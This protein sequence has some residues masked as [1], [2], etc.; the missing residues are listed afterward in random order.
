MKRL[1]GVLMI[2]AVSMSLYSCGVVEGKGEAEKIAESMFQDRINNGW[3][4]SDQYYS[5]LFWEK[6]DTARWSN[7]QNLVTKAHGELQSFSLNTWHIKSGVST[8]QLSGTLVTLLYENTYEQGHVS[9]TLLL[10]K[11]LADTKYS[12]IGHNLNSKRIQE[13]V[14]KG[15]EQAVSEKAV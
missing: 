1:L 5:A 14:E 8:N 3:I 10:Y 4:G 9:E 7:I 15:I 2:L 12:I 13:L 6:T 11:P